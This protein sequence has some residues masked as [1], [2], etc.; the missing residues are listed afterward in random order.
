M[1]Y[2]SSKLFFI[3]IKNK[4]DFSD[5]ER[6]SLWITFINNVVHKNQIIDL[7]IDLIMTI[8]DDN[9]YIFFDFVLSNITNIMKAINAKMSDDNL[10][11]FVRYLQYKIEKDFNN[12]HLFYFYLLFIQKFPKED[13]PYLLEFIYRKLDSDNL[14][15]NKYSVVER[16]SYLFINYQS[17]IQNLL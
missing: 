14:N 11:K 7:L 10:N 2:N 12:K 5:E 16:I 13:H 15:P 8:K 1:N 9:N 4:E 6:F 3:L 17:R